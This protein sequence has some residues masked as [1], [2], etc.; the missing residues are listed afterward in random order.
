[1]IIHKQKYLEAKFK[2][3]G[4]IHM[5]SVME[6]KSEWFKNNAGRHVSASQFAWLMTTLQAR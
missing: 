2:V 6:R 5:H 1:M 4:A 3:P